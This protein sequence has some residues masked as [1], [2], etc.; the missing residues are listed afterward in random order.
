[1]EDAE[2]GRRVYLNTDSRRWRDEYKRLA[3]EREQKIAAELKSAKI[4][5]IDIELGKDTI[6]PVFR[7]FKQR[8]KRFR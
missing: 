5:S 3:S 4:D 6:D 2:T 8:E 1:M 7:F